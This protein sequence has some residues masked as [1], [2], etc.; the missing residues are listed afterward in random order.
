MSESEFLQQSLV[1][2]GTGDA[3]RPYRTS[4]GDK[5]LTIRLGDFPDEPLYT[6]IIDGSPVAAF[7]DWPANWC[8]PT[9]QEE[10]C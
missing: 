7:D 9:G 10:I 6:L 8:R 4:V 5:A 1:W 3:I 2:R